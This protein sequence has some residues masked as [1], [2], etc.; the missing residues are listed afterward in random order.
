[1]SLITGVLHS[2]VFMYNHI[3]LFIGG[4]AIARILLLFKRK[5]ETHKTR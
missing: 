4:I 3:Y 5:N 1:M 2:D